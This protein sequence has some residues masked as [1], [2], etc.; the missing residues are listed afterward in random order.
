L[1][2]AL[3]LTAAPG[4]KLYVYSE[5]HCIVNEGYKMKALTELSPEAS[6]S[7]GGAN[8]SEVDLMRGYKIQCVAVEDVNT[9]S[10]MATPRPNAVTAAS[11]SVLA[12]VHAAANVIETAE[13]TKE[14]LLAYVHASANEAA[15]TDKE[16][17]PPAPVSTPASLPPSPLPPAAIAPET[18]VEEP[19]VEF[20]YNSKHLILK[21][22]Y[23]P[24]DE[25][26]SLAAVAEGT[27]TGT[28]EC[29]CFGMNV[30]GV[31]LW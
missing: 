13:E 14:A 3:K 12:A 1:D 6:S 17:S 5:N 29:S 2:G 15:A 9:Q 10:I 31:K 8:V 28:E 16:P 7:G 21:S 30:G 18:V 25:D 24:L 19:I 4:T 23:T 22:A 27:A 26:S 11:P 20:V